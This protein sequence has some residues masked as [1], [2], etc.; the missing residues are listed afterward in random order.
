MPTV[1]GPT[2]KGTHAGGQTF[3]P[4]LKAPAGTLPS[5]GTSS[6]PVRSQ[7]MKLR[8]ASVGFSSDVKGALT[9]APK[10]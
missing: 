9:K 7:I 5:M 1:T 3:Q 10:S 2:S 4:K 6:E 8:V